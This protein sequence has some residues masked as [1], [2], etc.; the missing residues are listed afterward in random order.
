MVCLTL[1][2][3]YASKAYCC[4]CFILLCSYIH[5]IIFDD[6]NFINK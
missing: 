1:K 4:T 5:F 6:L 3:T 2:S